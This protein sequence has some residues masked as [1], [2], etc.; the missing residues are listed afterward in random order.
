MRRRS[1]VSVAA[2][3]LALCVVA[4]CSVSTK[5]RV[6]TQDASSSC[7]DLAHRTA[8]PVGLKADP[9][10][11]A[12]TNQLAPLPDVPPGGPIT[13][14][15]RYPDSN[16]FVN[17]TPLLAR[18]LERLAA[19]DRD[20]FTGGANVG[21]DTGANEHGVIVAEFR[22]HHGAV[23]YFRVHLADLCTLAVTSEPLLGMLGVAY[24]RGDGV[25]KAVFVLDNAEI[26]LN[27]CSCAG[28]DDR[29]ALAARWAAA[30]RE[31]VSA[32]S[33]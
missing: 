18:P 8:A 9:L 12:L 21:Y 20:G 27:L 29:A 6:S 4:G 31:Q 14:L 25:V 15:E 22:D 10:A 7:L 3:A 13:Y 23:D 24:V 33:Q 30:V 26:S 11:L 1:V 17:G 2:V 5:T 16:A 28:V 19:L 32:P